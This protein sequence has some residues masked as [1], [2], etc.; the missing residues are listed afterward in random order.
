MLVAANTDPAANVLPDKLDLERR[1]NRHIALGT[2]IHFCLGHQLAR[3]EGKC[4]LETFMRAG[5]SSGW[6]L[7]RGKSDGAAD[8]E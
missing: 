1:P 7:N 5:L 8:R 2:G 4:A 6:Q 3:L